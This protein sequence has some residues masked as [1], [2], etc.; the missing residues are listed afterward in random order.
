MKAIVTLSC[1][2]GMAATLSATGK[3]S[4]DEVKRL[5]EAAT[6]VTELRTAP[7]NGIPQD[8][9]SKAQCVVVI[10]SMKKA[11]FLVGGEYGSGVMSCK[12]GNDWSSPVFM[13]LAKGS[14]GFQIGAQSTDLVLVVM[15][16]RG[17]DKLLGNK[18]TLGADM[19]VAAGPVGRTASAATDAQL[20]AEMLSYSRSQ[21]L[22]AG[23][24]LSGGALK[25]DKD[26]MARA[27]GPGVSERDVAFGV[28]RQALEPAAAFLNALR[29]SSAS[30][31]P[32]N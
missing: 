31:A 20:N 27:Y 13:Q 9:W 7:D 1:V 22:F 16:K 8:L 30:A 24:N 10:P 5:S 19:S 26:A 17:M 11:A 15:N 25:A 3:L 28:V 23:V 4:D 6:V 14:V 2:F 18:V 21:G 32:A 12:N 29:Q